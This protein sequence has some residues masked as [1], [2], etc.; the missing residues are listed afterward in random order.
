MSM[1]ERLEAVGGTLKIRTTAGGATRLKIRAP[2][3][4]GRPVTLAG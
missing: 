3:D 4:P 1:N 2:V